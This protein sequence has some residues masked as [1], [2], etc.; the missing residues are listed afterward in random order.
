LGGI[1]SDSD[2][3]FT[4]ADPAAYR[5]LNFAK[6]RRDIGDAMAHGAIEIGMV[7]DFD[8]DAAIAAVAR[9]LGALPMRQA[10]FRVDPAALQ[11][12]FTDRRGSMVVF[13]KG[14]ADQAI[15]R[16]EWPTTDDR[17]VRLE[18]TLDLLQDIV[19]IAVQDSLRET[20]G[21][22]Y[23]PGATSAQSDL[24]PG[25][26]TFSIQ[27]AVAKTDIAATRAAMRR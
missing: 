16:M 19:T 7:G 25:W 4:L 11:R 2:P 6:L 20:M 18:L 17:D 1:V 15:V 27:A 21:K 14:P 3:R 13:H 5:A 12:H 24:W 26:G 8:E 9:S 22:T 23:S 10:E